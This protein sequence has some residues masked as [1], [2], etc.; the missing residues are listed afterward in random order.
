MFPR[1]D[2][3]E[4]RFVEGIFLLGSLA[5][6]VFAAWVALHPNSF[7]GPDV[8]SRDRVT[9]GLMILVGLGTLAFAG[10]LDIARRAAFVSASK[11]SQL[12]LPIEG[13]ELLFVGKNRVVSVFL[14]QLAA[15]HGAS[16]SEAEDLPSVPPT[17]AILIWHTSRE[18]PE[19]VIGVV[20]SWRVPSVIL[21]NRKQANELRPLAGVPNVSVITYPTGFSIIKQ[22]LAAVLPGAT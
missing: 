16:F 22:G 11:E 18:F 2:A 1:D 5:A 6:F 4:Y 9:P 12:F 19:R 8:D 7:Y 13:H 21:A 20:K 14:K 3:Q 17:K 15:Q 10:I